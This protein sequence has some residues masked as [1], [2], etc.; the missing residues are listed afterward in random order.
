LLSPP[1]D[2][3]GEGLKKKLLN[4][5]VRRL[6]LCPAWP[7]AALEEAGEKMREAGGFSL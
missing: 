6:F 7:G 5:H 2:E 3:S 4:A 1:L